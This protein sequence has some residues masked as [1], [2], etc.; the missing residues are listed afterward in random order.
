MKS[1]AQRDD[2]AREYQLSGRAGEN[3]Y[4]KAR[5]MAGELG[6]SFV[7]FIGSMAL[8]RNAIGVYS[9]KDE[10]IE[11]ARDE[12]SYHRGYGHKTAT[13]HLKRIRV[14]STKI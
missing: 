3:L 13:V 4:L 14:P 9:N 6:E 12:A 11:A 8:P 1:E 5:K 7:V 10:A 2:D